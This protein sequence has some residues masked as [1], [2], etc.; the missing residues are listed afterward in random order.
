MVWA[1]LG[2]R[3]PRTTAGMRLARAVPR[4]QAE[5]YLPEKK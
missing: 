2:F 3:S 1:V 5:R 4:S